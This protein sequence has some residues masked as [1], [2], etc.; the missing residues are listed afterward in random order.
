MSDATGR[1]RRAADPGTAKRARLERQAERQRRSS[2]ESGDPAGGAKPERAAGTSEDRA[3]RAA[4]AG[5]SGATGRTGAGAGARSGAA[6]RTGAGT[7]SGAAGRTGA[8]ARSG[9]ASRAGAGARAGQA[10]SAADRRGSDQRGAAGRPAAAGGRKAAPRSA[11]RT[12][13]TTAESTAESTATSGPGVGA[14]PELSPEALAEA[15]ALAAT[16]ADLAEPS[17]LEP[18][19][20]PDDDDGGVA[21][22]AA[23]DRE[24]RGRRAPAAGGDG[25]GIRLQR[26]LAAA[27]V[28]SRRA[29]EELIEAGRVAVNGR[30]VSRQGM[31]VDPERDAVTVDGQRIVVRSDLIHVILNKPV[32]VLSAMSDAEGRPTVGE[33]VQNHATR[34]FHVGR[35]D[36]DS[37][38]LLLLTNDGELGHRLTHPSHG[39]QKTYL[40]EVRGP[41]QRGVTARL[42]KGVEL[43]DGP[44]VVDNV[45]PV[46]AVADRILLEVVLHEGRN[47]V[48]RR[49][50]AEVGHP[51]LRL[52]RTAIGPIQLGNLKPGRTRHLTRHEVSALYRAAGL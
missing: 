7:R 16:L 21:A 11:T 50:F 12:T 38:G 18:G 2:G 31:R 28:A 43:E 17:D 27:G 6:G 36:A 30:T 15:R 25:E 51:V 26:V 13:R 4:P 44:V 52:V 3:R 1:P 42:R 5:R 8:A 34:L 41:L 29:S 48:V 9:S 33:Y 24:L 39:V 46:G 45:H 14:T 37:E 22:F 10:R 49:L 40:V 20:E 19:T 47:H 32:G 23:E 35:L